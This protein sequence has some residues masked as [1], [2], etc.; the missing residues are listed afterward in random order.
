MTSLAS[1]TLVFAVAAFAQDPN[2]R[3]KDANGHDIPFYSP[4]RAPA[5]PLA[6][7]SPYTNAW[8]STANNGTLNS[9]GAI[10]WTG[11]PLGWEGIIT[12]DGTSYEYLGTGM[13]GLP[14]LKNLKKAIPLSASYDSQYSNFTLAAGPVHVTACFLSPVTPMDYCRTSIPLSYFEASWESTDGA[15]HDVQLYSD[16]N[17]AWISYESDKALEWVLYGDDTPING[18]RNITGASDTLYDWFVNQQDPYVFGENNDFPQWGNLSYATTPGTAKN[19]SFQSGH[20]TDVRFNYIMDRTLSNLVDA[21]YRSTTDRE[22]IF[23]FSHDF[24]SSISGSAL[25]TIGTIQDPIMRYL[26]PGGVIPL[27]PYWKFCYGYIL[28]IVHHHYQDYATIQAESARFESQLKA[29]VASYYTGNVAM[30]YSNN[31]PSPMPSYANLSM[32]VY[33]NG[34]DQFGNQY[35]FDPENAY[36]FLNPSNFSGIAIPDV[37]EPESYYAIVALSARQVMGAYVFA[38]PPDLGPTNES[39]LMFQKEISSDG[40]VNTVDVMYPAMPF[41]LYVNPELLRFNLN[42]LFQNQE[43]GFYPNGYSMHDLGSSFPNATGHVEGNDEYMPVEESGNM[44]IMAYA[45]YKFSGNVAY[46][47]SNYRLLKQWAQYLIEFSLIPG[48]QLSTDDFA[49]RLIN[50][51]NL[52]I[53]GIIALKAMSQISSAVGLDWDATN[54]SA[55]ASMYYIQWESFAVDPSENHTLLAYQWRSSYG[56][57][58]NTY[59]DKLLSLGIIPDYIYAMQSEWYPTISQ[60]FGVPLDSRHSYTKS[61]WEMWTAATCAPS[62]RR[63]FVNALAYWLNNTSTDR[64]FTDLYETIDS[65]SYPVSPNSIFFIARPVAG[66]HFS[67]LALLKA[68]QNT[69]NNSITLSNGTAT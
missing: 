34:T 11:D 18:T 48:I 52:A 65:G 66:G 42:P 10:F 20:S 17:G 68:G 63:L 51:T 21:Q 37:S 7:R 9:N 44:I 61:D 62:T 58:Y 38:A 46:L 29:D 2:S 6:V 3:A 12:V 27:A 49:G 39:P 41:F 32:D 50:Q 43:S 22:P 60:I 54:F 28:S 14:I 25:Y 5:L 36:G 1:I 40:N 8:V 53:K 31:T 69:G 45:Y 23:A 4:V 47:R 59:P 30:I 26:T 56:L 13:S 57:L 67:L 24:G 16:V 55:T 15:A 35:I 64:A 33:I 19:F